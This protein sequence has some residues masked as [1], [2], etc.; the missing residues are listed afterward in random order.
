MSNWN[1]NL[2]NINT[3]ES[4]ALFFNWQLEDTK[5]FSVHIFTTTCRVDSQSS[6]SDVDME[7]LFDTMSNHILRLSQLFLQYIV[8]LVEEP[9][10]SEI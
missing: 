4:S 9:Q 1:P 2:E 7:L 6:V 10:E 8:C 5:Y 3:K